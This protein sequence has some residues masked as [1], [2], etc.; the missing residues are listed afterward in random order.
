M[1]TPLSVYVILLG[2][3]IFLW[4]VYFVLWKKVCLDTFRQDLFHL[5]DQLFD[6]ATTTGIPYHHPAYYTLRRRLH[7]FIRHPERATYLH[8]LL[9]RYSGGEIEPLPEQSE[10]TFRHALATLNNRDA[11]D[12]LASLATELETILKRQ[13][14]AH[15]FVLT[16]LHLAL[17][18]SSHLSTSFSCSITPHLSRLLHLPTLTTMAEEAG[19]AA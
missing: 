17:S 13:V 8:G 3:A 16:L 11:A 1:M 15:S 18:S 9:L 12:Q 10:R 2:H 19:S 4:I 14:I 7:G 6:L 5:R